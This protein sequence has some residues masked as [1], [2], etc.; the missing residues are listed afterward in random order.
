MRRPVRI[1]GYLL[2]LANISSCVSLVSMAIPD[3]QGF[4]GGGRQTGFSS[5]RSDTNH[6]DDQDD[7]VRSILVS[8][9]GCRASKRVPPAASRKASQYGERSLVVSVA[10]IC[11]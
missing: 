5:A 8:K 10:Q 7:C 6:V 3:L 2:E 11:L 4:C 9:A 1:V